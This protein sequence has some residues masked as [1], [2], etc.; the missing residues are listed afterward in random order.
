MATDVAETPA[1]L[2][3]AAPEAPADAP[4][5]PAADAK[6]AKAKKATAPK[7]RASPTHPPYAEVIG[8]HPFDPSAVL[9]VPLRRIW[10]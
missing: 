7:K 9:C 8:A 5:A 2:V 3:D 10:I 1:P 4:A 6:P